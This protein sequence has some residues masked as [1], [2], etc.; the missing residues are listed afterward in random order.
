L[1]FKNQKRYAKGFKAQD[2][3]VLKCHSAKTHRSRDLANAKLV[4]K[5][6]ID[7]HFDVCGARPS[8]LTVLIGAEAKHSKFLCVVK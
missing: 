1:W 7:G 8:A 2:N 3:T 6:D 4:E 5:F